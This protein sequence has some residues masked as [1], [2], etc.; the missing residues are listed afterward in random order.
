MCYLISYSKWRSAVGVNMAAGYRCHYL[1]IH[2]QN[3]KLEKFTPIQTNKFSTQITH[4]KRYC[5]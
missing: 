3:R 2:L 5:K 1:Q 4:K